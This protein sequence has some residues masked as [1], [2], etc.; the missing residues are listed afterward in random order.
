MAVENAKTRTKW[1]MH[2][3]RSFSNGIIME[4]KNISLS[5]SMVPD[6]SINM[7]AP[8]HIFRVS[9]WFWLAQTEL[10]FFPD[11]AW[12]LLL[13]GGSLCLRLLLCSTALQFLPMLLLQQFLPPAALG[14]FPCAHSPL[15]CLCF[16]PFLVLF[17]PKFPNHFPV[18]QVTNTSIVSL[19]N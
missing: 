2:L 7:S 12:L 10:S 15:F 13:W 11:S 4:K 18:Q 6:C 19:F 14:V 1:C 17:Y 16:C 9:I 8:S 3:V 5:L